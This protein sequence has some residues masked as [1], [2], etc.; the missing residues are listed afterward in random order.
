M[1]R[2]DKGPCRLFRVISVERRLMAV[3]DLLGDHRKISVGNVV[4]RI[5][6]PCAVR[7]PQF[8][9]SVCCNYILGR[10]I[11]WRGMVR[12]PEPMDPHLVLKQGHVFAPR[13]NSRRL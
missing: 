1:G 5:S 9:I 12:G 3:G 4:P 7:I 10:Q 6:Y 2:Y 13:A 8:S 11:L